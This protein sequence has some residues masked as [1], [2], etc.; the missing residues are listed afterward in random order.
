M[1][2]KE[3]IYFW[4][5]I[6]FSY[7]ITNVDYFKI[8]NFIPGGFS[9][10]SMIFTLLI[11]LRYLDFVK[12]KKCYKIAVICISFLLVIQEIAYTT[13]G[14]RPLFILPNLPLANGQDMEGLVL[15]Q[16][17][18]ARSSACF[19]EPAHLAVYIL[20]VLFFELFDLKK[21]R[22]LNRGFLTPFA[23]FLIVILVILRSGNGF[24]GLSFLL[25]IKLFQYYRYNSPAK[26]MLILFC[27][28]PMIVI[29]IS[30][31]TQTEQGSEMLKRAQNVGFDENS[32]SY[33]RTFRGYRLYSELPV[34]NM[35][36]GM[37]QNKLSSFIRHSAVKNQF[38]INGDDDT[39]MNGIQNVLIHYGI[40][41]LVLYLCL[42]HAIF[43]KADKYLRIFISLY[44]LLM[45]VSDLFISF[46]FIL[47][48]YVV[49]YRQY[50]T[51]P[52]NRSVVI[53]DK[54]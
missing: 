4:I 8:T 48:I 38:L 37:S 27:L 5:F 39:Y 17:S 2:P 44:L 26:K 53:G 51:P 6:G 20:P 3:L 25:C 45:M 14:V 50:I 11:C 30:G 42:F 13:L 32:G 47:C 49:Q 9:F 22:S 10:C 16:I 54:S 24:L 52:F 35:I 28:V 12:F 41:G 7:F 43:R 31:Y 19:R 23:I 46:N 33:D 29:G 34:T 21:D 40:I 36:I 15:G 18:L 1:L